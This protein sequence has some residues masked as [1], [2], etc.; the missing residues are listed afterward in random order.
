MIVV[1]GHVSPGY[2]AVRGAFA[3][4]FRSHGEVGAAVAVVVDSQVVVD[5]WGGSANPRQGRPW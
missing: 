4:N 3:E 2:E 5:L 1:H